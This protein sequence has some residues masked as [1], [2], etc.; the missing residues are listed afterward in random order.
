MMLIKV[1][2]LTTKS[3]SGKERMLVGVLLRFGT[4]A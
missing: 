2:M 3:S 4:V 1:R